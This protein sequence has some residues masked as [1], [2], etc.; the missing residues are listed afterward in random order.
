MAAERESAPGYPRT[1]ARPVAEHLQDL[2]IIPE[3][4][5]ALAALDRMI[6]RAM[7]FR[8]SFRLMLADD[9]CERGALRNDEHRPPGCT[10]W[11]TGAPAPEPEPAPAAAAP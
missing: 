2:Q 7:G 3:D 11:G 6:D 5:S 4:A 8:A 1:N 9:E 10:C